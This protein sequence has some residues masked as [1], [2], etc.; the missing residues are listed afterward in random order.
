M[1]NIQL[2][3]GLVNPGVFYRLNIPVDFQHI[4]HANFDA[5]EITID[6]GNLIPPVLI[7]VNNLTYQNH[8]N[9][10][11]TI[12]NQWILKN[13]YHDYDP[14]NPTKLMFSLQLGL[15]TFIGPV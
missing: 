4:I 1:Q 2:N 11:N 14:G 5:G 13:G 10:A 6:L 8:H 12:I 15:L 7:S 3:V 9:F